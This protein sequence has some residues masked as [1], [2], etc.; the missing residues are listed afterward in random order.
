MKQYKEEKCAANNTLARYKEALKEKRS[1]P[2]SP[3]KGNGNFAFKYVFKYVHCDFMLCNTT[4]TSSQG[5]AV[6]YTH[7]TL[8]T[9]LLV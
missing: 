4:G 7:L 6:S 2:V 1:A 8:P 5:E 3:S 9:I